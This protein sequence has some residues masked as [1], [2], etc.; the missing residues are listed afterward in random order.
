VIPGKQYKPE[1]ILEALR[2][3]LLVIVVPFV[4]VT[5]GTF[6]F[7]RQLPD[8]YQAEALLMIFPQRVPTDYV[9]PTVTATLNER[10]QNIAQQILSRSQLE[11]IIEQFDLYPDKRRQM[12]MEDV[13]EAMRLEDVR[14]GQTQGSV[15][16]VSFEGD[17]PRVA[18]K[19]TDEL[20]SLFIRENLEDRSN[21]AAQTDQFIQSQLDDTRRQLKE[22]ESK[23]EEFRRTNPGQMPQEMQANQQALGQTQSQV[24]ALQESIN[25]DRD[26]QLMLRRMLASE[27]SGSS[28]LSGATPAGPLPT[29]R[30]LEQERMKLEAMRMRLKPSHPDIGIQ[31]RLIRD[32]EAKAAEEALQQ[33]L[34]PV[35]AGDPAGNERMKRI[36]D[37]QAELEAL[38]KQL[39]A[40][41]GSE[42]KTLSEMNV[43]R[44]RISAVPTVESRLTEL[45]R[46]YTTLQAV[47]QSLL[48]KSQE[49]RMS[50]NLERRQIGEQFKMIDPARS[51]QN[52]TSPNRP[53][54]MTMGALGGLALGLVLGVLLEYRDKSLRTEDDVIVALSLPVLA[55]VPT[56]TTVS[57]RL[58]KRRQ[59]L[60]LASSGA[61]VFVVCLAVLAWKLR[62]LDEWM[63]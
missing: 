57:E 59:R 14:I 4:L 28:V 52:P 49:A 11:R 7:V 27:M 54:M 55:M 37:L 3:R 22:K 6:I 42:Q 32:L 62:L 18:Q 16:R 5:A 35:S 53:R 9:R 24:L 61:V 20:A 58:R 60:V 38:D 1:D 29:A 13:V 48:V 50:T 51:P 47:Y 31:Q 63:W 2:R 56:M 41:Q 8:R 26:R 36:A 17:D 15:F 23:L 39:A 43:L 25:R 44:G 30:V 46:D 45:M 40:K 19:V 34:S 21:M 10:L 12:P 33:P